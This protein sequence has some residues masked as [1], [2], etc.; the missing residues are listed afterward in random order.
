MH[1]A[2]LRATLTFCPRNC[3]RDLALK[4]TEEEALARGMTLESFLIMPI[5][6]VPRYCLLLQE[7]EACTDTVHPDYVDLCRVL[8]IVQE[9]ASAINEKKR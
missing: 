5:Q 8:S 1:G 2:L 4:L 6:R 3:V 7:I 9:V